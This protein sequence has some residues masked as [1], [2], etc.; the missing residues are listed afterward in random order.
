MAGPAQLLPG[1]PWEGWKLSLG[2]FQ[3]SHSE[4]S[5]WAPLQCILLQMHRFT[6]VALIQKKN[7]YL[8]LVYCTSHILPFPSYPLSLKITM[9]FYPL[10]PHSGMLKGWRERKGSGKTKRN[11]P[12]L[13]PT[14]AFSKDLLQSCWDEHIYQFPVASWSSSRYSMPNFPQTF[15]FFSFTQAN[16]ILVP[17][18]Y[19]LACFW[20]YFPAYQVFS[21]FLK[22]LLPTS[23]CLVFWRSCAQAVAVFNPL[24]GWTLTRNESF[25][26]I[27]EKTCHSKFWNKDL[28]QDVLP[29]QPPAI[30]RTEALLSFINL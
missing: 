11:I 9:S 10:Y 4:S 22:T 21:T 12:C 29:A 17:L 15:F 13:Y 26:K 20:S 3:T 8:I 28:S 25:E 1:A 14:P 5:Q 6:H 2:C 30:P 7:Q 23:F 16:F 24:L 27:K 19:F 18:S